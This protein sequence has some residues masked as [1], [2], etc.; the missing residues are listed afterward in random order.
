MSPDQAHTK[1]YEEFP[2][3]NHNQMSPETRV[4]FHHLN[5]KLED[6]KETS[7]RHDI[8]EQFKGQLFEKLDSIHGEQKKTNGR[9]NGM[10]AWKEEY[11]EMLKE[12]KKERQDNKKRWADLAWRILVLIVLLV[13]GGK[14]FIQ[15]LF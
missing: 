7:M 5:E 4:M 10:E 13:L 1:Y 2:I 14:E 9:V 6:L 12:I 8:F 11:G 15:Y 3:G